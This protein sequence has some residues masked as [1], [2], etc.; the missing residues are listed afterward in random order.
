[1][2]SKHCSNSP[3]VFMF[4]ALSG[5]SAQDPIILD[6]DLAASA[7]NITEILRKPEAY[8]RKFVADFL[9][10]QKAAASS[11]RFKATNKG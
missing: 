9:R 7:S 6:P 10:M 8:Q 2:V 5:C 1:M 11:K 3:L 4:F